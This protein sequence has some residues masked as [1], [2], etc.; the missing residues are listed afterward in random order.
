MIT[1]YVPGPGPGCGQV[2]GGGCDHVNSVGAFNVNWRKLG[3]F[4]P[5]SKSIYFARDVS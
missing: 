2:V 4:F 3:Q 1:L 5:V